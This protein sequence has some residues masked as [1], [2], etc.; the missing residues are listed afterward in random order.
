[1][2][3]WQRIDAWCQMQA[4]KLSK[5]AHDMLKHNKH[6]TNDPDYRIVLGQHQAFQKMRS[7]IHGA[8]RSREQK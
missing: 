7:F 6:N 3:E 1:M 5:A 8:V 2:T 4:D